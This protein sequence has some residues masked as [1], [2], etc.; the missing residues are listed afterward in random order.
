MSR[1]VEMALL[2]LCLG[3]TTQACVSTSDGDTRA[4]KEAVQ[5]ML[6]ESRTY[7]EIDALP[8]KRKLDPFLSKP[9]PEEERFTPIEL[10]FLVE[11]NVLRRESVSAAGL[12]AAYCAAVRQMP[13]DWWSMPGSTNTGVAR[14]LLTVPGVETCLTALLDDRTPLRYLDGES[15]TLAG[16][17]DWQTG[18][19]AAG[20]LGALRHD[21]SFD[22]GAR[23]GERMNVRNRWRDGAG[24]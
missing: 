14:R 24:R 6:A 17:L 18:D 9:V 8:S 2:G 4:I 5:G 19:L 11:T 7:L 3:F 12:Q 10:F 15:N 20:L 21:D 22:H 23:L 16:D 13:P 1:R